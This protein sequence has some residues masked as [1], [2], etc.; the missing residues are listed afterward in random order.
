YAAAFG[1][2]VSAPL[3]ALA[4]VVRPGPGARWTPL[5][6]AAAVPAVAL[7][8]LGLMAGPVT[9]VGAIVS[10]GSVGVASL[11]LGRGRD[12]RRMAATRG[13]VASLG[14]GGSLAL[15]LAHPLQ[16]RL[17]AIRIWTRM[18]FDQQDAAL[19]LLDDPMRALSGDLGVAAI[20]VI[21]GVIALLPVVSKV[22]DARASAGFVVSILGFGVLAS[23]VL[24]PLRPLGDATRPN[25]A[26]DRRVALETAG[27]VLP[28]APATADWH[29]GT[30]V[31]VGLYWATSGGE[32]VLPYKEGLPAPTDDYQALDHALRAGLG[33][34]LVLEVDHR[35]DV[36]RLAPILRH[37]FHLGYTGACLVVQDERGVMGCQALRLGTPADAEHHLL[38]QRDTLVYIAGEEPVELDADGLATIEGPVALH[39]DDA[40]GA[41]RLFAI[42][43]HD[44]PDP[45]LVAD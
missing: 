28:I 39:L 1:L 37:A 3:L 44:L 29:P 4:N 34:D 11:R 2:F 24:L 18:P 6:A 9:F 27:V 36:R 23:A 7:A 14:V 31:T 33:A 32:R 25:P 20:L 19:A 15:A 5:H 26:R 12:G 41:D 8:S 13:L 21:C 43:G 16:V 30:H 10:A 38:V 42:L 22:V 17:Q 40:L 35:A 45:V